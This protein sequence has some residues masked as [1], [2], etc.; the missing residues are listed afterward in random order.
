MGGLQVLAERNSMTKRKKKLA[1]EEAVSF[2][3]GVSEGLNGESRAYRERDAGGRGFEG[4][5]CCAGQGGARGAGQASRLAA[6]RAASRSAAAFPFARGVSSFV[7][8]GVQEID[9]SLFCLTL[10]RR[11]WIR[12]MIRLI[13]TCLIDRMAKSLTQ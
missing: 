2:Q 13:A 1:I 5:R 10:A 8:D 12:A 11:A 9:I 4:L 7:W 3:T 6:P